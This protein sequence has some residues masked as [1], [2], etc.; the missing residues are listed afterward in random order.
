LWEIEW[1]QNREGPCRK[2]VAGKRRRR[3]VNRTGDNGGTVI[4][5]TRAGESMSGPGDIEIRK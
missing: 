3:M 5:K 4:R 2:V 1:E